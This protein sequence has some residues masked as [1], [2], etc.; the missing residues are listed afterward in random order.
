MVYFQIKNPNLDKFLSAS[1]WKMLIYFMATWNV[2]RTFGIFYDHLVYY[3]F[4]LVHFSGF[5]IM[6]QEI[7]GN[8]AALLER[9]IHL[10]KGR[11]SIESSLGPINAFIYLFQ[12][13]NNALSLLYTTAL[14]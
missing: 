7:S 5:G 3:R 2:L 9:S 4:N 11:P 6:Y 8:P 14:L 1:D 12:H 10:I 13:T